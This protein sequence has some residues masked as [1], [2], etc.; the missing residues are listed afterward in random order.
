MDED[1]PDRSGRPGL[2]AVPGG[3]VLLLASAAAVLAIAGLRAT[4]GIVAPVFLALVLTVAVH[5]LHGLIRR[6]GAAPWVAMLGT[7]AAV[8]LI[9]LAL[10]GATVFAVARLLALLPTYQDRAQD[11]VDELG[12]ALGRLGIGEGEVTAALD[13]IDL[14]ALLDALRGVLDGLLGIT[15]DLL[16]VV[17]VLLFMAVDAAGFTARLGLTGGRRPGL[18]AA[19]AG[20]AR[21]TRRYFVVSTVFGFVVAVLDTVALAL[22][23]VP[24]PLVWG[25]FSFITN[26]IPNIGFVIGLVPPALL[27]LL[28]GGPGTMLAVIAFYCV[29]NVIIQSVI[30]PKVVGDVVGLSATV[31]FVSLVFWTW[32]VGPLGALL[33]IPLTVLARAVLLD[34]DPRTRWLSTLISG[35][36]APAAAVPGGPA[37]AATAAPAAPAPEPAPARGPAPAPAVRTSGPGLVPVHGEGVDHDDVERDDDG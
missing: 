21:G 27:G 15:S 34:A 14:S 4:A 25:L 3:L 1:S 35:G 24:L 33:A 36:P 32:V 19:L 6:W 11:V 16:L 9:L 12:R 8:Y 29:I 22:L 5:P 18:T 20:F 26:Y 2:G 30:Q 10:A 7:L 28:E 37:P 23:G 13:K 31:S 17:T